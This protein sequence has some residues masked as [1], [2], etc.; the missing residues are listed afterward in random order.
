MV[1]IL[2]AHSN[3]EISSR[4]VALYSARAKNFQSPRLFR[5]N[6]ENLDEQVSSVSC[7]YGVL[8]GICFQILDAPKKLPCGHNFCK[9]CLH[10]S[11]NQMSIDGLCSCPICRSSVWLTES[12]IEALDD[13]SIDQDAVERA[14]L[15]IS[16]QRNEYV[17]PK[18][19]IPGCN[20][21]AANHCK[22]CGFF[23]QNHISIHALITKDHERLVT[24]VSADGLLENAVEGDTCRLHRQK[25]EIICLDCVHVPLQC[26]RCDYEQH[27]HKNE[28]HRRFELDTGSN[29]LSSHCL[30]LKGKLNSRKNITD[31]EIEKLSNR[32]LEIDKEYLLEETRR[33]KFFEDLISKIQILE[34]LSQTHLEHL[35][36][37]QQEELGYH[38]DDLIHQQH[39]LETIISGFD[40]QLSISSDK[41]SVNLISN[42]LASTLSHLKA[43]MPSIQL[44]KRTLQAHLPFH[45]L[46]EI[47]NHL[48][49]PPFSLKSQAIPLATVQSEMMS[50]HFWGVAYQSASDSFF[51][52]NEDH[53]TI[54]A[55]NST[56]QPIGGFHTSI[57]IRQPWQHPRSISCSPQGLI[58]TVD[59]GDGTVKVWSRNFDLVRVFWPSLD[60]ENS[61]RCPASVCF[62]S[63]GRLFVADG[64]DNSIHMWTSDWME[65][66]RWRE[67]MIESRIQE[68]WTQQTPRPR[69]VGQITSIAANKS[70]EILILRA[71]WTSISVVNAEGR[72]V[73]TI[74][75]SWTSVDRWASLTCPSDDTFAVCDFG[76]GT[77]IIYMGDGSIQRSLDEPGC[78]SAC[79]GPPNLLCIASYSKKAITLH[80]N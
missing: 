27:T 4:D 6:L 42:L 31:E 21:L 73:R 78:I 53:G 25:L 69:S 40:Q 67:P 23:C 30:D 14:Q 64:R 63:R 61:F 9:A 7:L 26:S 17:I 16:H 49:L 20:A 2:R 80:Q 28:D 36:H 8:C 45:L 60:G 1:G 55:W 24:V 35:V 77:I 29:S 59:A 58:A 51:T 68:S 50:T 37:V 79:L 62:D 33:S 13:S 70:D 11:L 56:R 47:E 65:H 46:D 22:E 15:H 44:C 76:L 72:F 38:I 39:S 34:R 18:C 19:K 57:S 66:E 43:G 71:G 75:T 48:K 5:R 74:P 10:L 52:C 41:Q 32:K 54:T 3:R 12:E